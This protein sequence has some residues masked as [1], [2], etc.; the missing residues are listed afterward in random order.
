MSPNTSPIPSFGSEV[1]V[2]AALAIAATLLLNSGVMLATLSSITHPAMNGGWLTALAGVYLAY[3][4]LRSQAKAGRV[5]LLLLWASISTVM[6]LLE[7][8]LWLQGGWHLLLISATRAFLFYPRP[9][10]FL[11]DLALG[12]VAA[13]AALWTLLYSHSLLLTIWSFFLVHAGWSWILERSQAQSDTTLLQQQTFESAQ[14]T[15]TAAIRRMTRRQ[16]A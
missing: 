13:A 15:A 12:M 11:A 14:A 9:L 16:R 1:I 2:A 6:H 10:A 8:G 5:S 7:V 4:C 3:L